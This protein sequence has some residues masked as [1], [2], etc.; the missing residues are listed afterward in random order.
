MV[1]ATQEIK[2]AHPD[3][4]FADIGRY[5]GAL[6]K[7]LSEQEKQKY[8]DLAARDKER[9][10]E[11]GPQAVDSSRVAVWNAHRQA[12]GMQSLTPPDEHD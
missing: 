12:S 2:E 4:G 7:R 9:Y 5:Q 10:E 1:A 6:W 8:Q 3:W 11:V